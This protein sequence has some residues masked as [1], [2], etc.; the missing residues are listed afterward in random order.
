[1][2]GKS[3]VGLRPGFDLELKLRISDE[4]PIFADGFK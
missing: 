3:A 2:S 4:Q 1:V